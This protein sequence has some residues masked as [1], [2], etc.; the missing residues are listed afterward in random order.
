MGKKSVIPEELAEFI[1]SKCM[2][3]TDEQISKMLLDIYGITASDICVKAYRHRH[4]IYC[5][6]YTRKAK[7]SE[8]ITEPA[9]DL[10]AWFCTE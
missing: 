1:A 4:G 9:S 2:N 10:I 6:K 8:F 3:Y 5:G 7:S